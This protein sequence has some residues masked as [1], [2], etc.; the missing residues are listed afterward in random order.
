M[1]YQ[2]EKSPRQTK[3][4]YGQKVNDD[5]GIKR[6]PGIEE[7]ENTKEA[8]KVLGQVS[9]LLSTKYQQ[10]EQVTDANIVYGLFLSVPASI[11]AIIV[12]VL[13]KDYSLLLWASIIAA[14]FTSLVFS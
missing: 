12:G 6:L 9:D 1:L 2:N 14:V 3:E 4:Q 10:H 5:I 13:I 11:L 7:S 8:L